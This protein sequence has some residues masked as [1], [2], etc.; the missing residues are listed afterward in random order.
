MP[1]LMP[2]Y[3][4][5]DTPHKLTVQH[6]GY[7]YGCHSE[8]LADPSPRGKPTA[9]TA[10]PWSANAGRLVVTEWLKLPCGHDNRANDPACHGCANRG[11][12]AGEV[13]AKTA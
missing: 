8:R 5:A 11:T 3:A 7:L 2:G 6:S 1:P 12:A 4:Y 10:H 13:M 9:Y